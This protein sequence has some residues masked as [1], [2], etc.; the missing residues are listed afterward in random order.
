ML[1]KSKLS[2]DL[3][4]ASKA[5]NAANAQLHKARTSRIHKGRARRRVRKHRLAGLPL[6]FLAIG[7][8][9]YEYPLYDNGPIPEQTGIVAQVQL[10]SMGNPPPSILNQALHG[11]ST[12]QMLSLGSQEL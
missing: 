12:R 7:N 8:S 5:Q 9:W 1:T 2:A 4:E 10:G 3:L 6:D 11:Q